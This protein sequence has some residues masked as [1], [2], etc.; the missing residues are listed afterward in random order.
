MV[1]CPNC[2]KDTPAASNRSDR[3]VSYRCDVCGSS[4]DLRAGSAGEDGKPPAE[5]DSDS[6]LPPIPAIDAPAARQAARKAVR[7]VCGVV[8]TKKGGTWR[9]SIRLR[10]AD[11][12][13]LPHFRSLDR[14]LH[15]DVAIIGGGITGITAAYLLKR[16]GKSV[17][18]LERRSL[19]AGRHRTH[20]GA[21]HVRHRHAAVRAGRN[22]SAPIMRRR[23]GTRG[24]PQSRRLTA[25]CGPRGSN[26]ASSGC[27][28]TC[29]RR[30]IAGARQQKPAGDGEHEAERCAR[31]R[32]R[33][34]NWASTRAISIAS[35]S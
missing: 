16:A 29:T 28:A 21:S 10:L 13:T 34:P 35:R 9:T 1:D 33:S 18:L 14:D 24:W 7:Q 27:P 30:R 6:E 32:S 20:D 4:V 19:P 15:V 2:G 17:A 8:W 31:K 22:R 11:T 26:A 25:S 5:R 12:V 23:P 3:V